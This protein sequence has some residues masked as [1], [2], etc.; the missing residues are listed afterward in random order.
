[1]ALAITTIGQ[2]RGFS[3]GGG[4]WPK[5]D[6]R[7]RQRTFAIRQ[8]TAKVKGGCGREPG[9][10]TGRKWECRNGTWKARRI[11]P[12]VWSPPDALS[13]KR[14]CIDMAF[15]RSVDKSNC[16]NL[17][18]PDAVEDQVVEEVVEDQVVDSIEVPVGPT[19]AGQDFVDVTASQNYPAFPPPGG[20]EEKPF[21]KKIWFWAVVGVA[22][23]GGGYM[24]YSRRRG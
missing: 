21:Y 5:P 6:P 10:K 19:N 14:Y 12:Y 17:P 2:P 7:D 9:P 20:E 1:M 8:T 16:R 24:V 11:E 18:D 13:G 4:V 15:A 22:A 23:A 3:T